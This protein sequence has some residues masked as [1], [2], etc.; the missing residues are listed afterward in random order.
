M[1]NYKPTKLTVRFVDALPWA[2]RDERGRVLSYSVRDTLVKGLMVVVHASSKAYSVQRDLYALERDAQGR[3]VKLG[4][5]RV[6]LG[7][8]RDFLSIEAVRT[9]ALEVIEQVRAGI[10]PN[11][12]AVPEA[13]KKEF[14]FAQALESYLDRCDRKARRPSTI[15][16]YR[17][18]F[19]RYLKD[20]AERPLK[21]LGD[22]TLGVDERHRTITKKNGPVAA[23]QSMRL[24]RAVYRHARRKLRDLPPPPTDAVD[25]ND[26]KRRDVIITDWPAFWTTVH[27]LRNPVTRDWYLFLAACRT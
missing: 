14:T 20:W 2:E 27:E 22:D 3:R 11:K 7:D 5:R 1:A 9:K 26:E 8:T 21:E 18:L 15:D 25:F 10:D 17:N 23:N 4:T 13:P 12:P 16:G 6:R 24:V 19:E